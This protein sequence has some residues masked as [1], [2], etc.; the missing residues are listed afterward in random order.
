MDP[1]EALPESSRYEL[2]VKIATGGM[3]TVYVGRSRGAFGRLFAIKRAHPH[4]RD[5]PAFRRM[6]IEEAQLASRIH[7]PNVVAVQ[8]V[9]EL[10]HEL[11]LVMDYVE[12]AALSDL[13]DFHAGPTIR[14]RIAS[15]VVLDAAA[16]LAA[17]HE[18]RREEGQRL[19]L[20]HRDVSPHN[21]LVGVDGVARLTDFGIAKSAAAHATASGTIR[22]K[23][24]YMAP[25]YVA[26]GRL[27]QRSDVF[28]LGVVLW[29]ALSGERL[30]AASNEVELLQVV[31]ACDV[32]PLVGVSAEL[33]EIV[34]RALAR[35]PDERFP[36]ASAF[37]EA[38]ERVARR[39]DLVA[40]PAEVG[41][42]VADHAADVLS[43][44]RDA[45]RERDV[46]PSG[47]TDVFVPW[48]PGQTRTIEPMVRTVPVVTAPPPVVTKTRSSS[49]LF[50]RIAMLLCAAASVVIFWFRSTLQRPPPTAPVVVT[51][52]QPAAATPVPTASVAPVAPPPS[53]IAPAESVDPAPRPRPKPRPTEVP[54][55]APPNPYKR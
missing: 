20:V 36:S 24:A 18:L 46:V 6:F 5:D 21:V 15:R 37:A 50:L 40:T 51:T 9:E 44:R 52:S 14:A 16:G 54:G 28:A 43:A 41:S 35:S 26:T 30:F 32:P 38:L 47:P 25:E 33:D 55:R 4:L 34:A 12:G 49:P 42:L 1:R 39:A 3:G 8:D 23:L 45:M 31:L 7:H 17:A 29:E 10:E 13:R 27:D 19:D 2:L 11:L 22:G 48:V 53:L